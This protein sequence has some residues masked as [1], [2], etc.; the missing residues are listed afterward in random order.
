MYLRYLI[1]PGPLDLFAPH[2]FF[3]DGPR[4]LL[5]HEESY[6]KVMNFLSNQMQNNL[7]DRD[8][9]VH[10]E[11]VVGFNQQDGEAGDGDDEEEE[12]EEE[13]EEEDEDGEYNDGDEM[14]PD[15]GDVPGHQQER[16]VV[17]F[18]AND[19]LHP[20]DP[21][22]DYSDNRKEDND[23]YA[24]ENEDDEE[25]DEGADYIKRVKGDDGAANDKDNAADDTE[26]TYYDDDDEDEEEETEP[27]IIKGHKPPPPQ[28]TGARVQTH[29]RRKPHPPVI[30]SVPNGK[31]DTPPTR[32]VVLLLTATSILLLVFL[33]RFI[34]KRRI[35]FRYYNRGFFKL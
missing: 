8:R 6:R 2:N 3:P 22:D 26:Y 28:E 14:Y 29:S 10:F 15:A 35:H 1:D 27:G 30:D 13:E 7:D 34:R 20:N 23:E 31:A 32:A 4:G 33:Y 17:H 19:D 12:D 9:G 24:D 18:G 16:K 11:N 21:G 25:E 5:G